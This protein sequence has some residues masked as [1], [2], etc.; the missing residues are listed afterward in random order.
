L[1][2]ALAA[3]LALGAPGVAMA[4]PRP[5]AASA[6]GEIEGTVLA[7]DADDLVIDL[8]QASGLAPG[9][10][11]ELWRPFKLKHPVTGKVLTDRFRIGALAVGQVRPSLSLARPSGELLRAAQRGDVVIVPRAGGASPAEDPTPAA[12]P[13]PAIAPADAEALAIAAMFDELR[14]QDLATRI[15]RYEDYV[16]TSPDGRFAHVLFEEA[17]ALRRL[18][19]AG[20]QRPAG[21]DEAPARP[22]LRSFDAPVEV[23]AEA[24]LQVTVELTD[25]AKGALLHVRTRGQ[26]A[27]VTQPMEALGSGYWTAIVPG[28]RLVAPEIEYFIEATDD[29]GKAFTVAGNPS[30]PHR[31]DVRP[32]PR[33]LAPAKIA[34]SASILADFA[35]YNRL[36]D[37]DRVFQTEGTFG[38]RFRDT[39]VR[40]L[41]SGFGVYRGVG[42]TLRELDELDYAPRKVG[43]TYGYLEG[44]LGATPRFSII[45]RLAVGLLD[46]GVG[47]GA[48]ALVR[49]GSDRDTNLVLGGEVLGGV[50]LKTIAEL[51]LNVFPRFPMLLRSEVTN[52]PAGAAPSD[53]Q[54]GVANVAQG[55]GEIGARGIAQVGVRVIDPL[56]LSLRGSFQGRNIKHAG[57][58]FGAGASYEW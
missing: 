17:A 4:Q 19:Q 46:D 32:V 44:E 6:P 8:G 52:Q 39:G 36:R 16:R 29:A 24:P 21:G 57:P 20:Q 23:L 30:S 3:A 2:A 38:L 31:V 15:R 42:G 27:F 41:R 50:G 13:G 11:V 34:A 53:D 33:P 26:P 40:A 12:E 28:D 25:L 58:G 51:N 45:A 43:L 22:E 14:G 18:Y 10:I 37:N 9:A 47:G 5:A 54:I 49:I 7:I 55:D 1:A 48:Q 56:V 35:D